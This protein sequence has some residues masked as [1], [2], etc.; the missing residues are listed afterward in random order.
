M[1]SGN[2][3]GMTWFETKVISN[4]MYD[5]NDILLSKKYYVLLYQALLIIFGPYIARRMCD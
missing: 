3:L 5:N 4:F 1:S 2:N